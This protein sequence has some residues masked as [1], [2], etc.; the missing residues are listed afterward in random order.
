LVRHPHD[1]RA[2][3]LDPEGN[4]VDPALAVLEWLQSMNNSK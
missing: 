4:G 2:D 1:D 3:G